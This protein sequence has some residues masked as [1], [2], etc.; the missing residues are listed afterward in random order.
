MSVQQPMLVTRSVEAANLE[1]SA[2]PIET[3]RLHLLVKMEGVLI[4]AR[5]FVAKM[6]SALWLTIRY[7]RLCKL[8]LSFESH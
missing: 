3:V 5:D 4:H 1:V 7:L 6:L 8:L 2:S